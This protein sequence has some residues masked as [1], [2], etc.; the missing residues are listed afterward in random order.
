[1]KKIISLLLALLMLCLCLGS[2]RLNVFCSHNNPRR[3]VLVQGYPAQDYVEG[4]TDGWICLNCGE[5]V[6]PQTI[7]PQLIQNGSNNTDTDTKDKQ[8]KLG[9][10]VAFGEFTNSQ[11][12]AT[13]ASVVLD[14]NGKIV[15]CRIDAVYNRYVVDFND[16]IINFTN[17]KTKVELGYDYAMSMFGT[18]LVGNSTVKEWFEQAQEFEKWVI[19]KTVDEIA[20]MSIQTTNGY[21][22]SAD[23]ELLNAG[24][25]IEIVDFRDAVVKAC[26]DDQG[27]SFDTEKP[28][29]LG[30][31]AISE[32][33]NSQFYDEYIRVRTMVYLATSV[34]VEGK[35]VATLND[36]IAPE[37]HLDWEQNVI[38]ISVGRGAGILK[39]H[40]ELKE[41]YKMSV[42]GTNMDYNGDGRVLEWYEQSAAFS[43]HVV[44]MTANE[45]ANMPTKQIENGY[46]VSADDALL[47]AGCTIMITEMKEIVAKS[48]QNAR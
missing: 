14:N 1:M 35:I 18:S 21:V 33:D 38:E 10:G 43:K 44:G 5:M 11:I 47:S 36:A 17:L 6:I 9:M 13:I 34:V 8:Y 30:I 7:I 26:N 25:T 15:A 28:M 27:V 12:N 46:I 20:N 4:L 23:Q 40:R 24:C 16:E 29:T 39:T 19:G 2:C 45:V 48:V 3:I 41:D 37:I 42:Y 32:G 22:I 31:A